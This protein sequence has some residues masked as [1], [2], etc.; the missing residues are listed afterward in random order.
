M[1]EDTVGLLI[2]LT[3]VTSLLILSSIVCFCY[4]YFPSAAI[5]TPL[6][7]KMGRDKN[8]YSVYFLSSIKVL[9]IILNIFINYIVLYLWSIGR[10]DSLIRIAIL[11]GLA[12][13]SFILLLLF[14]IYDTELCLFPY[15][16]IMII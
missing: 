15:L 8:I 9:E 13:E 14:E 1:E 4:M 12:S 11:F 7:S 2:H 16:G 6:L 10:I 3:L 5:S